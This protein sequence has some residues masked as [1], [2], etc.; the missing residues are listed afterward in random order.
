[1]RFL[2]YVIV[3]AAS[4]SGS[5]INDGLLTG[6]PFAVPVMYSANGASTWPGDNMLPISVSFSG[7][8]MFWSVGAGQPSQ[9]IQYGVY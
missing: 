1:M 8:R 7:N 6:Y 5:L 2:G 9:I 3:S 4:G